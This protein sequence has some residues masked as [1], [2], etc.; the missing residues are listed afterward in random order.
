MWILS[1]E[2]IVFYNFDNNATFRTTVKHI[3]IYNIIL[4]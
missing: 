3:K 1:E 4:Y 2:N